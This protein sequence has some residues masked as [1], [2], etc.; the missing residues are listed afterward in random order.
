MPRM[1]S[2]HRQ[3]KRK[4]TVRRSPVS[5]GISVANR[6]G[7]TGSPPPQPCDGFHER[8]QNFFRRCLPIRNVLLKPVPGEVASFIQHFLVFLGDYFAEEFHSESCNDCTNSPLP[9]SY[10]FRCL[11]SHM[12]CAVRPLL[13][14][15]K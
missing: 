9:D 15:R 7:T 2:G 13:W 3:F 12:N 10:F 11:C 1:R 14:L 8:P 4:K 5:Q 6:S